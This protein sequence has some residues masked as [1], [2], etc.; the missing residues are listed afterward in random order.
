MSMWKQGK[1]FSIKIDLIGNSLGDKHQQ[2]QQQ[3]NKLN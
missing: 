2:Q 3:K 1:M